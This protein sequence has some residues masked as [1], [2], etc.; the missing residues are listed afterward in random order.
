MLAWF[1]LL[2][3]GW[4]A[5]YR[6]ALGDGIQAATGA[7]DAS[8]GTALYY[9]G[10]TL[11]TLGLGD[12]VAVTPFYRVLTVAEAA[13]GF[14]TITLAISYFL[15]VY[16]TLTCRNSF[17]LSLHQRSAGTGR[18]VEVVRALWQ[19]GP[20]GASV[21]LAEMA[22][23]MR[24][25]LETHTSYPVLPTFHLGRG[26]D[27]LPGILRTTWETATVLR[28]A[29]AVP[30]DRP[31]LA[32]TSVREIA[33]SAEEMCARLLRRREPPAASAKQ[34][35]QWALDYSELL[36]DLRAGGLPVRQEAESEYVRVRSAWD[37]A[38]ADLA[39]QLLCDEDAEEE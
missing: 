11:T 30:E 34:R 23:E 3:V 35:E 26:Y 6:P 19:E 22:T 5:V 14:A 31:E 32:G 13:M 10:Y 7:T 18:G 24:R 16:S 27:A 25:L 20:A 38:L 39:A 2:V 1:G 37:P 8:W 15:S 17:A 4:A 21:L 36:D 9:S 33:S 29:V 12:V 28:T